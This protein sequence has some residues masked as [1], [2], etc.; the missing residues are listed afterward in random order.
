MGIIDSIGN[1]EDDDIRMIKKSSSFTLN[2]RLYS[3][4]KE[5]SMEPPRSRRDRERNTKK[6]FRLKYRDFAPICIECGNYK[7]DGYFNN[8]VDNAE[9]DLWWCTKCKE[10]QRRMSYEDAAREYSYCDNA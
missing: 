4:Y 5:E 10:T 9:E 7:C 1:Q 6:T 3:R 8:N 2:V